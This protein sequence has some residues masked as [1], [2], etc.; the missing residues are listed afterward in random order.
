MR[1]RLGVGLRFGEWLKLRWG[2]TTVGGWIKVRGVVG[3][4]VS[5]EV[6]IKIWGVAVVKVGI[7]IKVR[8]PIKVRGAAQ[9]KVS[10]GVGIKV[11]GWIK[12]RCAAGIEVP[13]WVEIKGWVKVQSGVMVVNS[14]VNTDATLWRQ[15]CTKSV[16]ASKVRV[17]VTPTKG[18]I[19]Q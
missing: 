18:H 13:V 17:K 1:P 15:K 4:K 7:E 19:K 6:G 8:G 2:E 3:I 5:V 9:V 10:V 14:I 11:G 16:L 12:V